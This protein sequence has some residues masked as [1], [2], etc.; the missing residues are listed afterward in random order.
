VHPLGQ[1]AAQNAVHAERQFWRCAVTRG[2]VPR[3]CPGL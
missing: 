3:R 2:R 1:Q